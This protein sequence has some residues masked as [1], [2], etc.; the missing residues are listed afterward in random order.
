MSIPLS[1][2]R[3]GGPVATADS[4]TR[5]EFA[6]REGKPV[7]LT[8]NVN[9]SRALSRWTPT[10]LKST[11]GSRRVG[12][13]VSADG[14]FP[15][16]I[17][18]Y[19]NNKYRNVEMTVSECIDRMNG[20]KLDPILTPGEKCARGAFPRHTGRSSRS[21]IFTRRA[22]SGRRVYSERLDERCGECH[23]N[24]LRSVRKPPGT[25]FG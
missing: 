4:P 24:S 8:G 20:L 16:G 18:P 11:V 15:G 10:Y 3:V 14:T 13:Y 12:V 17:G 5:E 7:V 19:D 25:N 23:A 22:R 9:R 6:A 21:S 1:W 2:A